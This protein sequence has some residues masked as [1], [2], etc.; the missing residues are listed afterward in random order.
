VSHDSVHIA[1]TARSQ[2]VRSVT[3]KGREL[4]LKIGTYAAG[5]QEAVTEFLP[6]PFASDYF[7][8]AVQDGYLYA[9]SDTTEVRIYGPDGTVR[10]LV[11]SGLPRVPISAAS[12]DSARSRFCAGFSGSALQDCDRARRE[13]QLR[14]DYPY[15]R[16]LLVEPDGSF[17]LQ[18]HQLSGRALRWL[19]GFE[20][21]GR[22]KAVLHVPSNF[23]VRAIS[24]R[25]LA[26]ESMDTSTQTT[27]LFVHR[28]EPVAFP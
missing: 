20:P 19:V 25:L 4:P 23:T 5:A 24:G 10:L 28:I 22:L 27:R 13:M 16:S 8:R 9:H 1:F 2:A 18:G 3:L 11:N 17:W 21:S 7:L 15:F 26:M 6:R 14:R 12:L